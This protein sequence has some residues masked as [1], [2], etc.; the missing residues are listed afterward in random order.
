EPPK[1]ILA[2]AQAEALLRTAEAE[3]PE[4]VP[5]LALGLFAGI[6]PGELH[7]MT[8][9][10]IRTESGYIMLTGAETKTS[11]AR[12]IRIRPNLAEWLAAHHPADRIAA[13]SP[14]RH[15]RLISE[16]RSVAG[17]RE[18]QPDVMRHSFATYAYELEKDAAH[19]AAEMGHHGTAVF[20]RHYRALALPGD[21]AAFFSIMPKRKRKANE[22]P[23]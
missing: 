11:D 13:L 19:I 7:R 23:T 21:G 2:V 8:A 18:W 10:S 22:K 12:T 20:F 6:R 14:R 5:Y 3:H 16:I 9:A 1:H 4:A 15:Q 17:I